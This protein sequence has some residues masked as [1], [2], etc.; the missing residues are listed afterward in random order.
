MWTVLEISFREGAAALEHART[1][2]QRSGSRL[3]Q[4]TFLW[5]DPT[6]IVPFDRDVIARG[7]G[8]LSPASREEIMAGAHLGMV[9]QELYAH[10]HRWREFTLRTTSITHTY[11]ALSLMSRRSIHPARG[12]E[13]LHLQLVPNPPHAAHHVNEPSLFPG[14]APPI[15]DLFFFLA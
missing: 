11:Q 1:F 10:V 4:I 3:I 6:W 5:D 2:L 13:K 7:G 14:S 8:G 15:R 9:I 12:L